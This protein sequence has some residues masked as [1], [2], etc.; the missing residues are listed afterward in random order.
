[1]AGMAEVRQPRGTGV[2]LRDPLP[3]PAFAGAARLA[4]ELGYGAVLLPEIAGRDTL[5]ALTG[6]A[7]ETSAVMLGTG[8]AP[9]TSRTPRLTA[10]AA[11]TLQERSGGRAILGLGTGPAV[12]G[13][14]DR[15]R[16]VVDHVRA[17]LRGDAVD[18]ERASLLPA[19]PVPIWIAA[20]GPRALRTAGEIA[21]GVLLNW[22]TPER[23]A[24]AREAIRSAAGAA[25]RDPDAVAIA[26][27][28]RANLDADDPAG[29]SGALRAAAGE[30]ASYP[31]Y[32]RQ[33]AAAG[34]D[35]AARAAAAAHREGRPGDVP[36]E[37]VRAVTLPNDP[38]AAR[39]RL[40]A[41]RSAGADLP[42]VYPVVAGS[43]AER[44]IAATVRALAP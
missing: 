44:S 34:L 26:V 23:V 14:L 12:A 39:E 42:V 6:L 43:Q 38:A 25:G 10:M 4:E 3:W 30:Y 24:E 37:L 13:A 19:A 8:V 11:A 33:F 18:G 28:V 36:D 2:A 15:L 5:A 16:G 1:M 7:G 20:L 9:M 29:A 32:A 31:A 40:A 17:L 27:Y 22:C 21:D 41:Y 35:L